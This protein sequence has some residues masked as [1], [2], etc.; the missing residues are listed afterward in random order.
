MENLLTVYFEMFDEL[1]QKKFD[2][3][4]T[5]E[6]KE[7]INETKEKLKDTLNSEAKIYTEL[8]HLIDKQFEEYIENKL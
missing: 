2:N 6:F 3:K 8:C 7:N 1:I 5:K 4:L